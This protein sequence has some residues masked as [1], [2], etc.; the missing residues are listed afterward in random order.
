MDEK[1]MLRIGR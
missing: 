1:Q